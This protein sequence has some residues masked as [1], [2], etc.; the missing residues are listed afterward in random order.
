VRP[1]HTSRTRADSIHIGT[2]RSPRVPL[3]CVDLS[4]LG[5]VRTLSVTCS[6]RIRRTPLHFD[7]CDDADTCP[8]LATTHC[9]QQR[10]GQRRAD[11][12]KVAHSISPITLPVGNALAGWQ[13][14]TRRATRSGFISPLQTVG[15]TLV[16]MLL[17]H[18]HAPGWIWL[19]RI[20]SRATL[21][22]AIA[23][24][25]IKRKRGGCV[26]SVNN[27]S[28]RPVHGRRIN[29]KGGANVQ[30]APSS[31]V[32]Q[33]NSRAARK[34]QSTARQPRSQ[35]VHQ[36]HGCINRHPQDSTK[37]LTIASLDV[38]R[39]QGDGGKVRWC[40]VGGGIVES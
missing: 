1:Q 22:E 38:V 14:T 5:S 27:L 32:P 8:S 15:P 23:H 36:V 24:P 25:K 2:E 13:L 4:A 11:L 19:L 17:H 37:V 12:R 40:R 21:K 10:R 18:P 30:V 3:D 7:T 33:G 34:G 9:G 39:G 26:N 28:E 35:A 16:G 31:Q 20:A 29:P 6:A